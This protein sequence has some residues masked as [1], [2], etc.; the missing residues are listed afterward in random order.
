MSEAVLRESA[1][2]QVTMRDARAGDLFE[3]PPDPLARFHHPEKHRRRAEFHRARGAA[4]QVIGDAR[5]F[6]ENDADVRATLGDLHAE[7]FLDGEREADVVQERRDVV[8]AVRVREHLRPGAALAH[9]LEAAVEVAGL[10]VAPDDGLAVD[11]EHDA[12]RPV[13]RGMRGAHVE[14]ERLCRQLDFA[15]FHAMGGPSGA[16]ALRPPKPLHARRAGEAG[17]LARRRRRR[18]NGGLGHYQSFLAHGMPSS[19]PNGGNLSFASGR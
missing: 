12:D 13:H 19:M 7:E 3:Q 8:Q 10:H 16:D 9:L 11:L 17:R 4:G 2:A 1:D 14:G 6:A 5:E 15:L 18:G